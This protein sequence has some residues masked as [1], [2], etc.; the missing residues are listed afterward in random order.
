MEHGGTVYSWICL[1]ASSI[2]H[3]YTPSHDEPGWPVDASLASLADTLMPDAYR[4]G[5][6]LGPF[7]IVAGF[8]VSFML[9]EL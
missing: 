4:E 8:F 5:G 6:K 3:E 1:R 7:A 2:R 9:A